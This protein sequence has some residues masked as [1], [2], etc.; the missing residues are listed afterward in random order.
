MSAVFTLGAVDIAVCAVMALN[1]GWT[2]LRR[3]TRPPMLGADTQL[4]S[5]MARRSAPDRKDNR[6]SKTGSSATAPSRNDRK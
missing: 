3:A 6:A 2:T 5:G 1:P 4:G